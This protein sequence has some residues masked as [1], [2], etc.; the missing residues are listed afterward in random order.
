MAE[1]THRVEIVPV[2]LEKHPNA[3]SLSIVR[4]EGYQVIVRTEDWQHVERGV[5]AYIQPDSLVPVDRPEFAFLKDP[6]K[7]EQTVVRIK[8]RRLRGEW[9]MGL[10]VPAPEGTKIGDDVAEALGVTHYDPPEPNLKTGGEA[11]K[12]PRKVRKKCSSCDGLGIQE[13]PHHGHSVTCE[14]CGGKGYPNDAENVGFDYP[15]YEVEAFRKYGRVVFES[16]EPVWVTEKIH[17]SNGRWLFDGERYY[18]GSHKEWKRHSETNLW[19]RALALYPSLTNFLFMNPGTCVYGEVYGQVQDLK[20]GTKPGELRIAVFDILHEGRWV[21]AKDS[22]DFKPNPEGPPAWT[23]PWVPLVASC[24][25]DFQ[26]L[27]ELAE[28]NSL[29]PGANHF[30]EGIVVKP[31]VERWHPKCGRLNL[32]IVSNQYLE[33]A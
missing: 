5:G 23:L 3:D 16:G 19:W 4:I 27:L 30:R 31:H 10:L 11:E 22:Q 14:P 25:F 21:N 26:K 24:E 6:K 28:G 13:D 32:K 29:I 15:R 20:Y 2:T 33:R 1:S 9:S 12:A 17:G 7:P 18:C 8:A